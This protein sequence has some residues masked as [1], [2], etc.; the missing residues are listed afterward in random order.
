MAVAGFRAA[1]DKGDD[2]SNDMTELRLCIFT[3]CMEVVR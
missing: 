1:I 2:L 3:M